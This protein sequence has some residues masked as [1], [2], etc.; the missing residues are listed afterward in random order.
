MAPTPDRTARLVLLI[1]VVL[2]VGGIAALLVAAVGGDGSDSAPPIARPISSALDDAAP[3]TDPFEGLTEIQLALG[4]D[5]LRLVVADEDLEKAGGLRGRE[6]TAPYD[7][8][9]FVFED[10]HQASFTMQG[11]AAPLAIGW[12]EADGSPV[13]RTEMVPCPQERS[14]CPPY[15]SRGP[16]RFAVETPGGALPGG[17]LAGCPS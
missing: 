6:A 4:E 2:A 8:M 9:L 12:Y 15:S 7:G 13:D 17:A 10:T 5:C 11:V 16:Y 1:G 14:D 3:A